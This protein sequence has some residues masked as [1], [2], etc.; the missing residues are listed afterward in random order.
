MKIVITEG[1]LQAVNC[2]KIQAIIGRSLETKQTVLFWY[3]IRIY[4]SVILSEIL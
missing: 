1:L 4:T 2:H 3:K